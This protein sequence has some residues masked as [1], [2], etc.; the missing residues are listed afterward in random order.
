MS[1]SIKNRIINFR[2]SDHDYEE[3]LEIKKY[4]ENEFHI[5]LSMTQVIEHIIK[6]NKM[7]HNTNYTYYNVR[8]NETKQKNKGYTNKVNR[9]GLSRF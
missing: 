4:L 9:Q 2:I 7:S 3:L 6:E 1:D 8:Q 5:K